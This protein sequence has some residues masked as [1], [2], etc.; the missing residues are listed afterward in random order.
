MRRFLS[1]AVLLAAG[2]SAVRAETVF[3][4]AGDYLRQGAGARPL[5]MGAAFTAVADD[6][7]AEYWNPAGLAFLDEY[8]LITMY[9]PYNFGTNLYYLGVGI[10]LGPNGSLAA[11]NLMLRSDGFQ[12]RDALNQPSGSNQSILHNA[13]SLSY[14]R[15]FRDRWSAGVRLRFLQQ[16][17]F[18]ASGNAFAL[19]LSGYT[20][21]WNGF[22]TGLT[23]TNLNRP[24]ITVDSESD[25]FRPAA[26]LGLAYRAPRDRFI[27]AFDLNKTER[28]SVYYTTGLEYAP[29][30]LL[31]LRAGWD[32]KNA[33]TAGMGF[34]F[35]YLKFDYAFSTQRDLGDYNKV[36]LTWR[37]GNVYQAK[38]DP[39]GIVKETES[40]YLEGLRNELKF[41]TNVPKFRVHRYV[42]AITDAMGKPV[43]TLTEQFSPPSVILWDM[44]DE[45]GRPVKRGK[46]K[47][48]FRVEYKNGKIWEER[49]A[50]RLDYKTNQV[51]DVEIRMKG[52]AEG[53]EGA[54]TA[55]PPATAAPAPAETPVPLELPKEADTAQ[56]AGAPNPAAPVTGES[57]PAAPAP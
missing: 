56:S 47:F 35:R 1:G 11:S 41:R 16:K 52:D 46:Y 54:D 40:I 32:E 28:Q 4:D 9:A 38:I 26:R 57:A 24:K 44:M 17:I 14:A 19:D 31:S 53:L 12:D 23:L 48:L 49:G 7:S 34:G 33:V 37:W 36:S 27:V 13:A 18:S 55:T 8:Q 5:G 50:F 22:S 51:P 6:A 39:E 20:K 10:P 45:G 2:L 15:A 25:E 3:G 43:R 30:P 42:L 21:P 29:T